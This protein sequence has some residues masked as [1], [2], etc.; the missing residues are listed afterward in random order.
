MFSDNF[1]I[2]YSY[3]IYITLCYT[4]IKYIFFLYKKSNINDDFYCY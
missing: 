3:L 2:I 1:N 4:Y